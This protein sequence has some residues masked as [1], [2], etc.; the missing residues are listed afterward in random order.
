MGKKNLLS[1]EILKYFPIFS[2]AHLS[3]IH[4]GGIGIELVIN[5]TGRV[6]KPDNEASARKKKHPS[7]EASFQP[8]KKQGYAM[9]LRKL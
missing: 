6:Q 7:T 3:T 4:P 8:I 9:E 5:K 1:P 2:H